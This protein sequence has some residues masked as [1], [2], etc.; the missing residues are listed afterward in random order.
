MDTAITL[1]ARELDVAP[2][3]LSQVC[4]RHGLM[5]PVVRADKLPCD[6]ATA[7]TAAEILRRYARMLGAN[8]PGVARGL[9]TIADYLDNKDTS[10][11]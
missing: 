9:R 3:F 4:V 1:V 5:R 2:Q 10:C 6:R 8:D 11:A 7:S